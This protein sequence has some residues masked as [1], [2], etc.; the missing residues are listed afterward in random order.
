M[1]QWEPHNNA[2]SFLRSPSNAEKKEKKNKLQEPL[3]FALRDPKLPV[4]LMTSVGKLQ[5]HNGLK[6]EVPKGQEVRPED[7]ITHTKNNV[8]R[9]F[10]RLLNLTV[11]ENNT[12]I[13]LMIDVF[14]IRNSGEKETTFQRAY[15]I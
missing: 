4:L 11:E 9:R 15:Y 5:N 8:V 14:P 1:Q 10:V 13:I 2:V 3:S 12:E 6:R 7:N